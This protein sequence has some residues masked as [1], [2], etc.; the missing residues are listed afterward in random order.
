MISVSVTVIRP[1]QGNI[2]ALES[3]IYDV[4]VRFERFRM[5]KRIAYAI[6]SG[7]QVVIIPSKRG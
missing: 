5:L 7:F 4:S 2:A 6:L 1:T 3:D